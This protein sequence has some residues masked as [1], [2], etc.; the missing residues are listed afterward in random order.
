MHIPT[1]FGVLVS[2]S[3][4]FLPSDLDLRLD[5]AFRLA[6]VFIDPFGIRAPPKPLKV[7]YFQS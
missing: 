5:L 3:S 7:I 6:I 1:F 4:V 2:P